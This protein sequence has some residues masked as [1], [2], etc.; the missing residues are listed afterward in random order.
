M[1]HI[2]TVPLTKD[3]NHIDYW[4]KFELENEQIVC[5]FVHDGESICKIHNITGKYG[6]IG[7][8]SYLN[9]NE[10]AQKELSKLINNANKS[11]HSKLKGLHILH[12][13]YHGL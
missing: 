4:A 7:M 6:V 8:I 5:E 11:S 3:D 13:D 2:N 12:G 1:L 9:N 10:N